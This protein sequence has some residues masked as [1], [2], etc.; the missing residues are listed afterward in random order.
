MKN[1]KCVIGI[2][3]SEIGDLGKGSGSR[4]KVLENSDLL[5]GSA[6]FYWAF[7]EELGKL[8]SHTQWWLW[9]W[10]GLWKWML[11]R[12]STTQ[13][14]YCQ[15]LIFAAN[16]NATPPMLRHHW[17]ATNDTPPVLYHQ[18]YTTYD[19]PPMLIRKTELRYLMLFERKRLALDFPW[20]H[21]SPPTNDLSSYLIW[22]TTLRLSFHNN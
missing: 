22:G 5:L 1:S 13:V 9:C 2:G 8:G 20:S 18:W 17:Y 15:I 14:D 10:S 12:H 21:F 6:T 19:T 7:W 3:S 16:T 4:S 11:E